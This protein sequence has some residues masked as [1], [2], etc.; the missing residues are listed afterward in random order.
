MENSIIAYFDGA[1]EPVNPSGAMGMGVI[2]LEND[3]VIKEYSYYIPAKK[4]NTNNSA[5]YMSFIR[6]LKWIKETNISNR[7]IEIFGDSMLVI[8]QMNNE[9][10]INGGA[11]AKYYFMAKDLLFECKKYNDVVIKWIP[12]DQN[13]L[14]DDLSKRELIKNVIKITKR[15]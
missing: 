6:I 3:V 2:I 7:K 12:R 13:Q 5:E 11:Y 9:W 1:T 4:E 10:G 15:K 8:K 14:A